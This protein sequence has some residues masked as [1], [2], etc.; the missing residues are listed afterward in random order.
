VLQP[1]GSI[2]MAD[3]TRSGEVPAELQGLLAWIVCIADALA[4]DEYA[5]HLANAGLTVKRIESHD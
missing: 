3:L 1:D 5:H 4:I 2:S